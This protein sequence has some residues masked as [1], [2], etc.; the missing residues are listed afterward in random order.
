MGPRFCKRGNPEAVGA[1]PAA[2][3]ASMGPRFCKRGNDLD[4]CS[5]REHP[6]KASMG[7]RFCKRGN[8]AMV[9]PAFTATRLQ[10]GHAFVSVET[11][12][13]GPATAIT[14]PLQWG[15]AFVSVETGLM[16]ASSNGLSAA[17]MGPRFCKRGNVRSPQRTCCLIHVLQWG[18]A[19]VSVETISAQALITRATS[20]F[21]G[22][23]LL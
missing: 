18:H 23:T 2:D 16:S 6:N 3:H 7:P 1:Q 15:H 9:A 21:N 8:R 19:F 13:D 12:T 5:P 11:A 4:R 20:C 22:A 14:M 10:W 17:S